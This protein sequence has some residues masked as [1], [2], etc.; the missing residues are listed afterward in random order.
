MAQLD[1]DVHNRLCLWKNYTVSSQINVI[2]K[3][4]P[5]VTAIEFTFIVL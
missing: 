2:E 1:L 4:G 3:K 5:F